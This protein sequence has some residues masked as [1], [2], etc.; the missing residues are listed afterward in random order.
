MSQRRAA[1]D[2][3]YPAVSVRRQ[4]E[5]LG[6][7][8]SGLY[9]QA[10]VES[11]STLTVKHMIDDVYTESPF[12]GSRRIAFVV[13]ERLGFSVNRKRASRLMKEMGLAA[14]GP[15]VN[16]SRRDQQHTVY[17]YLLR[18]R[19]V[20][21]PL[22]VWST[23]ITYVRLRKGFAYLVAVI[24]WF[25]RFVL[26]WS[27]SNTLDSEFCVKALQDAL[28]QGKPEIFNTDQGCQFT[29]TVFTSVLTLNGIKISMDGRGRALDNVFVE[30]LWRS[31]KY[32]NIY[33]CGYAEMDEARSGLDTYFDFYN[34]R[35]P[36]QSLGYRRPSEV[37]FGLSH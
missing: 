22:E 24:D 27:L 12:Y 34:N 4:C 25:S 20:Q 1:I 16:T 17:P 10:S 21:R 6:V 11:V 28:M 9:Y 3:E 23:D 30:R 32:E 13:S 35:R 5:L 31:V 37:H 15:T 14:I 19:R 18:G 2:A 7:N 8:R 29:S 33:P 36:H 26:S